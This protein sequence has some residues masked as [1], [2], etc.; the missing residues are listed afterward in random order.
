MNDDE[1][2]E[3]Y[4]K[5]LKIKGHVDAIKEDWDEETL[6]ELKEFLHD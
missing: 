2:E 4:A 1:I 3:K 6:A 5:L